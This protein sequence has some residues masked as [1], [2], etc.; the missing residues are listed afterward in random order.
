[1]VVTRALRAWLR[2]LGSARTCVPSK[3]RRRHPAIPVRSR[4]DRLPNATLRALTTAALALPGLAASFGPLASSLGAATPAHATAPDEVR[5]QYGRYQEDDRKLPGVESRY[6]PID[7]DY[8]NLGATVGLFDRWNLSLDYYQ[9]TWSGATPIASAPRS[10]FGNRASAPDG[11]SGATP[12]IEGDLYFDGDLQVLESDRFGTLSG[13]KDPGLVHT[14]SSASPE[15]RKEVDLGLEYEWDDAALAAIGGVS[16]ES[17]YRSGFARLAG[18][19]DFDRKRTSLQL[20]STYSASEIDARLDHDAVP[21][22]DLSAYAGEIHNR[23]SGAPVLRENRSDWTLEAGLNRVLRE[24]TQLVTSLQFRRSDGFLGNPYKVVEVAFI[25]P[26]QQFLAPPG[27]FYGDVHALLERRPGNRHQLTWSTQLL[28][29][30]DPVDAA[31]SL[32]YSLYHDDWGID[33]HTVEA[34]WR[35][36]L[37]ETWLVTPR[38]RYYSQGAADFYRP[39]LISQQAYL[40]VDSDPEGNILSL[41]PF[42][43]R[44]LP[45]QYSADH[46]LSGFGALSGGVVV[47]K[48]LAR[49]FLLELGFEYSRHQGSWR[50]GGGG[51]ADFADFDSWLVNAALRIDFS[52]LALARSAARELVLADGDG[53]AGSQAESAPHADHASSHASSPVPAGVMYAHTL[54]RAGDFM[55]GY[56]TM[57]M[58]RSGDFKE[59][60]KGAS[61]AVLVANACGDVG[62]SAASSSMSHQMHMLDLM[63][64]PTSWLSLMLMPTYLDNDMRLRA[65]DGGVQDVHSNHERHETGGFGDT[66]FGALFGLFHRDQHHIQLGLVMSAP[67]GDT[68]VRFRRDHGVERGFVHYDMQLGSGTWDFLPSLSYL[69]SRGRFLFGAQATG[70]VRMENEGPNGYAL[71]DEAQVS[72]WGGIDLTNW[73]AATLRGIYTDQGRIH[74]RF[75]RPS[76]LRTPGDWPSNAGGH[77]FD[78][79]IGFEVSVPRGS[80]EGM[81]LSVEWLQPLAENWNGFQLER[82]G[83]LAASVGMSF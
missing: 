22:I 73:L 51:E 41:T 23:M 32:R 42:S 63:F 16:V 60:S 31:I 55:I 59:G 54:P 47:Q 45:G 83:T 71:G 82:T 76:S 21:Y 20:S 12:F 34:Q 64:A 56:R 2:G 19:V 39:F 53:K 69:G 15:T 49:V 4:S 11:V 35:Q 62:C 38:V 75:D 13:R 74:G 46:R 70:I 66:R 25:D 29:D 58:R 43:H 67:T 77:L 33:A 40:L 1:M 28:Q 48:Q 68:S 79:G 50:A 5:I 10:L 8:L 18:R 17:D 52:T 9:D 57:Y 65:L 37:G 14:L 72:V 24:S 44:L 3:R 61:D 36:E 27:G 80:F 30:F 6:D 26:T 7:V 81:Q 78:L